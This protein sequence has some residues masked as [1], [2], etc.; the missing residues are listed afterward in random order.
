MPMQRRPPNPGLAFLLHIACCGGPLLIIA[1][2]AGA[3]ALLDGL[4]IVAVAAV[5][6][7]AIAL[8][9]RR[10]LHGPKHGRPQMD[11]RT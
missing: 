1:V 11:A 7:G 2:A 6:A 4:A 9:A 5:V 3:L 8:W 10:S